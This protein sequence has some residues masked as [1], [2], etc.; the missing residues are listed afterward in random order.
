[1]GQGAGPEGWRLGSDSGEP[2]RRRPA[3]H[4]RRRGTSRRP[5][6]SGS[7]FVEGTDHTCRRTRQ[8]TNPPPPGAPN[9][10]RASVASAPI[11]GRPDSR[12]RTWVDKPRRESVAG[13]DLGPQTETR[14]GRGTGPGSTNR[15]ASRSRDRHEVDKPRRESVAGPD[16]GPQTETRVGRGTDMRSTNR[17]GSRSRDRTVVDQPRRESVGG[18]D[19]GRPTEAAVARGT[20]PG[21]TNRC[22]HRWWDPN[23]AQR[24]ETGHRSRRPNGTPARV[25]HRLGRR[26]PRWRAATAGTPSCG[27][28]AESPRAG[29]AARSPERSS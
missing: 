2:P 18:P 16:L 12:D 23:L 27:A 26:T 9:L 29:C 15:D 6:H 3:R 5:G 8:A 4:H 14:V 21:S 7:K 20:G 13:P 25:P 10:R 1:M 28:A 22:E 11:N 17:D 24:D 19:R